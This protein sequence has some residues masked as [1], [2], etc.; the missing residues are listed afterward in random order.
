MNRRQQSLSLK[1]LIL[2]M[3]T[4]T[5]FLLI[6]NRVEASTPKPEPIRHLVSRGD[7]L[8][9]VASAV[10]SERDIR[11]IV[12]EIMELNALE[13]S[14]IHPGQVLLLPND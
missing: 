14:V 2:L 8:W 10:G 3:A 1:L 6:S 7:T 5:V 4:F 12:A 9:E 11:A 13:S